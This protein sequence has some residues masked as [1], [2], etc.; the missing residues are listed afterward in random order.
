[1]IYIDLD[2]VCVDFNKAVLDITGKSYY[3]EETCEV[4]ENF[5]HGEIV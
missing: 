1:M 3:G 5:D 4:L 2:G